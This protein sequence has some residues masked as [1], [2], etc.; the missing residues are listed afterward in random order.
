L[1]ADNATDKPDTDQ[2]A[3]YVTVSI[4]R[5]IKP[6][7]EKR[8]EQWVTGISTASASFAGH[9]GVHIMRPSPGD[10]QYT[11]VYR[12]DNQT[13]ADTWRDSVVHKDW[14]AKL[15]G[16]VEGDTQVRAVTGM[17]SWFDLPSISVNLHPIR[18]RMCILLTAVVY[19]MII[20]LNYLLA[21]WLGELPFYLRT[22]IIV[23]LQVFMMTYFVMPKLTGML[24]KWLYRRVKDD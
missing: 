8:Y 20:S 11:L 7:Q 23:T 15:D 2:A 10:N 16:L 19:I 3:N 12:F 24:K 5:R 17:E 13:H 6:G 9:M 4:I 22:S 1:T 21:P 18:W 14:A